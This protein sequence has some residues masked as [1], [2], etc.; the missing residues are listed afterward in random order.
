[1][2]EEEAKEKK[3]ER[4]APLIKEA[5]E[6]LVKWEQGRQKMSALFGEK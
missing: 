2:G 1:M 5:H 4:E 6:M 3:A